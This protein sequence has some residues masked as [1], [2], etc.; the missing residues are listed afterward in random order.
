MDEDSVFDKTDP[1]FAG[2]KIVTGTGANKIFQ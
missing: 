1:G 2:S